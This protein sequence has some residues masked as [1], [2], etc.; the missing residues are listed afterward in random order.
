MVTHTATESRNRTH[1]YDENVA[2]KYQE[3]SWDEWLREGRR[4]A[5]FYA[6]EMYRRGYQI[7]HWQPR[8]TDETGTATVNVSPADAWQY[9]FIQLMPEHCYNLIPAD[10][11][12]PNAAE[13]IKAVCERGTLPWPHY[14]TTNPLTGKAHAGWFL[15][16]PV[17]RD[18]LS[19]GADI[20]GGTV[21]V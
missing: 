13:R 2:R 14:I 8:V 5:Q 15:A 6:P 10:L 3:K 4:A 21:S 9:R 12:I 18:R 20:G 1:E 17:P 7:M 16:S 11:D 19:R